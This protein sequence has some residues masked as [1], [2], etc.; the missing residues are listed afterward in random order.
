MHIKNLYIEGFKSYAEPKCLLNFDPFF[1]AINGLNGTGKSNIL[2]SICFALGQQSASNFRVPN[3]QGLIFKNGVA[4]VTK[5]TVRVVYDNTNKAQSPIG[6]ENFD[7]FE[8]SRMIM[9]GGKTKYTLNGVTKTGTQ[10]LD[11]YKSSRLNIS[12][13]HFVIMQ[14]RVTK[15]MNMK[16]M[17]VLDLIQET[18]GTKMYE[19]KKILAEKTIQKKEDKLQQLTQ[20]INED[21]TP[22]LE[23]LRADRNAYIQYQ[24]I[25]R[26]ID[27]LSR[28]CL[29][30][31]IYKINENRKNSAKNIEEFR[32]KVSS[33]EDEKALKSEENDQIRLQISNIEEEKDRH[34][35]TNFKEIEEF[36]KLAEKELIG[37]QNIAKEAAK[38]VSNRKKEKFQIEKN[39]KNIEK[40]IENKEKSL[41]GKSGSNSS[42]LKEMEE[43][44]VALN[45]AEK[46]LE[47]VNA[48]LAEVEDGEDGHGGALSL[49]DKLAKLRENMSSEQNKIDTI[50]L[51][52]NHAKKNLPNMKKELKKVETQANKDE[53][54]LNNLKEKTETAGYDLE[55]FLSQTGYKEGLENELENDFEKMQK[56]RKLYDDL[57]R[58]TEREHQMSF[59]KLQQGNSS[60]RGIHLNENAIYGQ[61][62]RLFR[63]PECSKYALAIKTLLGAKLN[64]WVVEDDQTAGLLVD[65]KNNF[66]R[67]AV[68]V[69]PLNKMH[70]RKIN[71]NKLN[72]ARK[73]AG[74]N[75]LVHAAIDLVTFDDSL[76]PAMEHAF[77]DVL[78][79][80]SIEL[81]RKVAFHKDI[82]L[83]CFTLDGDDVNPAGVL[84]GGSRTDRRSNVLE[85]L[86]KLMS[87][88]ETLRECS[89]LEQ[90]I[91]DLVEQSKKFR[92]LKSNLEKCQEHY[93]MTKQRLE[94]SSAH[95][96]LN[97]V[98]EA[99]NQ[100]KSADNETSAI[101]KI[102]NDIKKQIKIVDDK[103][104][105]EKRDREN[106]LKN[107]ES[108]VANCTKRLR[109]AEN[110]ASGVS[111]AISELIEDLKN[112]KSEFKEFEEKVKEAD[113]EILKAEN[114]ENSKNEL[115]N[116]K[117][118]FVKEAKGRVDNEKRLIDN[119][120]KEI[121]TLYSKS[122]SIEAKLAK[123]DLEI[124]EINI[125]LTTAIKSLDSYKEKKAS[126]IDEHGW[127]RDEEKHFGKA[128]AY[129]FSGVNMEHWMGVLFFS[130]KFL[131][132]FYFDIKL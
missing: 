81:A 52:V 91:Y 48:G 12:S 125:K 26:E 90:R 118:N 33:I 39:I 122:K 53:S 24:K 9:V 40:Q 82:K 132:F 107:A 111:E 65:R 15:V 68:T 2:D 31:Q 128:G 106:R 105:N 75:D 104:K 88:E 8:V 71:R 46:N 18:T 98:K 115:V 32:Q 121:S 1:N 5:A 16:P 54:S 35:G 72:L 27:S 96:L 37:A 102:V 44:K 51:K 117:R 100:I 89:T 56:D 123:F 64:N 95:R 45:L 76:L 22:T 34:T 30:Y 120:S 109:K 101:Q 127:I 19:S 124:K 66:F 47:A 92:N 114:E 78:I 59:Q 7:E 25:H 99:E 87:L 21:L 70:G 119:A 3:M 58:R 57:K 93:E 97:E 63:I 41:K 80:S 69:L 77:S 42:V 23:K 60:N 38:E 116:E 112:M 29:A 61:L 13:G 50:N 94:T 84:T 6:L 73:I 126:I 131:F 103:I 86:D 67:E 43:A 36:L 62:C 11:M 79:C 110:E 4:G 108:N 55:H 113:E 17:E 74:D 85:S 20:V 49:A 14:G 83:R 10:I 130:W 129:D 28:R